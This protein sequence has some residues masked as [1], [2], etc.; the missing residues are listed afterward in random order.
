M[1]TDIAAT[2]RAPDRAW[3]GSRSRERVAAS[4]LRRLPAGWYLFHDVPIGSRSAAIDHVVVGPPGVFNV[5]RKHETRDV[6]VTATAVMV[7]GRARDYVQVA[8]FEATRTSA[9]L[10]AAA[11]RPAPV[12]SLLALT[13]DELVID[14]QPP[15]VAAVHV[16]DLAGWLLSQAELWAPDDVHA[17][18]R[19]AHRPGTWTAPIRPRAGDPCVC[20]GELVPRDHAPDRQPVLACSGFPRCRRTRMIESP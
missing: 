5:H 20:G 9:L 19:A 18:A 8:R 10:S 17:I 3:S 16:G 11:G 12:R 1:R 7:G 2:R 15:G 6:R 14:A 13:V 4:Y